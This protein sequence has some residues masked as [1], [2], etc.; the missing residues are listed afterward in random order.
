MRPLESQ[1]MMMATTS[2]SRAGVHSKELLAGAMSVPPKQPWWLK[3]H[4]INEEM[5]TGSYLVV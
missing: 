2:L 1:T 4:E 5:N 3:L